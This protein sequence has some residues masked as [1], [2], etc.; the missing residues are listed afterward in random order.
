[1]VVVVVVAAAVVV[2]VA[3]V[4]V[5]V[6]RVGVASRLGS[7]QPRTISAPRVALELRGEVPSD[8]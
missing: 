4:G 2:V 5:V 8:A 6:V 1:M 7:A 3:V